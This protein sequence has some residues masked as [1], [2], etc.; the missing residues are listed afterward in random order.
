M[1]L[2]LEQLT[3]FKASGPSPEKLVEKF[4]PNVPVLF[5]TS[6]QDGTVSSEDTEALARQLAARKQNEVYLLKLQH[7]SHIGYFSEHVEDTKNYEQLVHAL[8]ERYALPHVPA[9]AEA[10][11]ELLQ[12]TLLF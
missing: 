11:R 2:V 5:V 4:P 12:K 6:I 7:S 10:G 3:Q 9:W 8:Y 1:Q